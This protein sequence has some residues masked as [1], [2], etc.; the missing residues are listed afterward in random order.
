[1]HCT[2]Q[3]TTDSSTA[4]VPGLFQSSQIARHSSCS[5]IWQL[6]CIWDFLKWSVGRFPSSIYVAVTG[7]LHFG[8]LPRTHADLPKH[9]QPKPLLITFSSHLLKWHSVHCSYRWTGLA[10]LLLNHRKPSVDYC[11]SNLNAR[12]WDASKELYN[13]VFS[14]STKWNG[15]RK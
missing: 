5:C 12:N 3:I 6:P 4:G 10:K 9:L 13:I 1:M 8:W 2:P 15:L 14:P 11:K 7:S